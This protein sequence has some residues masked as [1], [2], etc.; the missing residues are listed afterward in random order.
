MRGKAADKPFAEGTF[1]I[2]AGRKWI[3]TR[4]EP[5]NLIIVV[6]P[7]RGG[8]VPNFDG[9]G[10]SL[11]SVIRQKM[12]DVLSSSKEIA[13][14]D[15]NAQRILKDARN[16]AAEISLFKDNIL[17]NGNTH[18]IVGW[19]GDR[20]NNTLIMIL[21]SMSIESLNCG[22][23]IEVKTD[24]NTLKDAL[25]KASKM[26]SDEFD[27]VTSAIKNVDVEK[28]DRLVPLD[29]KHK[30]YCNTYLDFD[31]TKQWLSYLI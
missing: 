25:K 21:A 12:R 26:S 9:S 1:I 30:S 24:L 11:D 5:E 17:S 28:W 2:F 16:Y 20:I 22:C 27:D 31:G 29:I 10:C 4:V 23:Y 3:I 15:P 6:N 19:Q 13:Y 7:A 18:I 14:L 8:K